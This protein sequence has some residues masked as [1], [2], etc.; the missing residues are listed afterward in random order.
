[1]NYKLLFLYTV[2][3]TGTWFLIEFLKGHPDVKQ[4]YLMK[5]F[6]EVDDWIH[7]DKIALHNHVHL[8]QP[9]LY[10]EWKRVPLLF[11]NHYYNDAFIS[12]YPTI[13][14]IRDPLLSL[15]T[16]HKRRDDWSHKFIVEGFCEIAR[17]ADHPNVYFMP[18]DLMENN[19][20]RIEAFRN[21]CNHCQI[22]FNDY[23]REYAKIWK[24]QNTW[25]DKFDFQEMYAKRDAAGLRK[26]LGNNYDVLL[27]RTD[28][29]RPFLQGLGY[30]NLIWWQN[31][32]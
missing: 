22:A 29:I 10:K 17:L 32:N 2:H 14:P 15:I 5:E 9:S 12:T 18:L 4:F 24:P 7:H 19:S 6:Y 21:L 3:H 31:E 13:I 28:I 11:T 1:M 27:A 20:Q 30:E 16:R 25:A 8:N 23:V 26:V